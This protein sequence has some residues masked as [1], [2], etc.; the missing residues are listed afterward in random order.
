MIVSVGILI[1]T[2]ILG[3]NEKELRCAYINV[4]INNSRSKKRGFARIID[5]SVIHSVIVNGELSKVIMEFELKID[6]KR[7]IGYKIL[8]VKKLKRGK[9]FKDGDAYTRRLEKFNEDL[10]DSGAGLNV[11]YEPDKKYCYICDSADCVFN[12]FISD[13]LYAENIEKKF[14]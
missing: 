7:Y 8:K 5:D 12:Y 9:D 1:L 11:L 4:S 2:V 6:G 13:V 14:K 3:A 10:E